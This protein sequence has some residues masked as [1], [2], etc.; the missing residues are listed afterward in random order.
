VKSLPPDGLGRWPRK[1]ATSPK[2][3]S[4][5]ALLTKLLV[6]GVFKRWFFIASRWHHAYFTKRIVRATPRMDDIVYGPNNISK[7]HAFTSVRYSN[8][9]QWNVYD[10]LSSLQIAN[11][12]F[13]HTTSL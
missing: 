2:T 5:L 10:K 7:L 12:C 3:L 9:L 8:K 1:A 6:N 13:F 11:K 4:V